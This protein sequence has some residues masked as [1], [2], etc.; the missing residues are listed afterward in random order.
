MTP[1]QAI[2]DLD[3]ALAADGTEVELQRLAQ[4]GAALIPYGIKLKGFIRGYEPNELVN[5]VTQ[6]MAK[7]TISPTE[8]DRKGWPGPESSSATVAEKASDRRVPLANAFDRL[9]VNGKP[10]TIAAATGLYMQGTLVRID[11]RILG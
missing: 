3:A 9:V 5:G 11:G 6:Q 2:A 1:E 4:G 10:R 8:I 7:F